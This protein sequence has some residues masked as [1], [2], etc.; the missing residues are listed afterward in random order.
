MVS[1]E[2]QLMEAQNQLLECRKDEVKNAMKVDELTERA[3]FYEN[4]HNKE[5]K[6]LYEAEN[7]CAVLKT[8]NKSL[9]IKRE[10][11]QKELEKAQKELEKIQKELEEKQ[12]E[13]EET[14]AKMVDNTGTKQLV[15]VLFK[16]L[17]YKLT[18]R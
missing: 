14:R 7:E 12:K 13:L 17:G 2:E 16:R 18:G 6:S 15:A 1:M 5:Q 11:T 3:D 9:K 10:E 4:L 8:E